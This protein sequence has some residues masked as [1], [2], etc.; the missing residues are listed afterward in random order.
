LPVPE[1]DKGL[2]AR[3]ESGNPAKAGTSNPVPGLIFV[4]EI[5]P[6]IPRR[7]AMKRTLLASVAVLALACPAFAQSTTIT[8]GSAPAAS[9]TIAPEQR[10]RIKTY[11]TEKKVKAITVKEKIAVGATLPADVEL[12]AVPS[13]WGPELSSFRYVYTDNRI[14]L[15][16]PSSRRVVQIIE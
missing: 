3:Q 9:V 16:E 15:V 7:F 1:R 12:V 10:T 8:T 13:D 6:F 11:V 4:G 5:T 2:V 14:A